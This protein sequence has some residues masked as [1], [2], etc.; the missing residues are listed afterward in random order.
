MRNSIE[1]SR[2]GNCTNFDDALCQ[3]NGLLDYSWK[4]KECIQLQEA[5]D[6]HDACNEVEQMLIHIDEQVP[7]CLQDNILYYIGGYIVQRLLQELQCEK[8]KKELL[9]DLNNPTTTNM[10]SYPVFARF[11]HWKQYGSLVLPSPEVLRILKVTEVIFKRRVINTEQG[12]TV[13]RMIDLKI[14]SAVV[15]QI[16][17]GVFNYV[18][19]H[20]FEHET[21]QE[22]DH[23]LRTVVQRYI[24]LRLKTYM[25]KCTQ[26]E[27]Y[28]RTYLQ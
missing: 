1:P 27:L 9:R 28:I 11:T 2:T 20:Y 26:C 6:I 17:N 18:D 10:S 5:D 14:E 22:M 24:K 4:K 15:Q 7:N 21:G 13:D 25:E 8:C 19:G 12:I 23:L 3:K 16:G